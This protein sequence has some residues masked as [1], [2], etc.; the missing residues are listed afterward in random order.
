[1][2]DY[3][4]IYAGW[5]GRMNR[6]DCLELC[7][8]AHRCCRAGQDLI[9]LPGEG[10][11]L[12][13]QGL[14]AVGDVLHCEGRAQCFG[15]LRPICCRTFPV[16]PDAEGRLYANREC[17]E[18]PWASWHWLKQTE[19]AW[20]ELLQDRAVR[21][22]VWRMR[23]QFYA[24][25]PETPVEQIE[26][27]FDE[28][29]ARAFGRYFLPAPFQVPQEMFAGKRILDAGC[30]NG[31]RVAS[32]LA[33]GV[34]AWGVDINPY[35][36]AHSLAPERCRWGDM[37]ALPFGDGEFDMALTI[38][39][40]EHLLDF[41]RAVAELARVARKVIIRVTPTEEPE[42]LYE[43]S[44]HVTFLSTGEWARAIGKH[45]PVETLAVGWFGLSAE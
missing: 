33:A 35:L 29:Y 36:V 13:S 5:S 28:G 45:G 21:E 26:R 6:H 11:W 23:T 34:D 2:I 22:W 10:E 39:V 44:T 12:R 3:A 37:R 18:H 30:G 20:R 41:E 42:N 19:E 9:L 7:R 15:A 8:G 27:P 24:A 40:L 16:H 32:L 17:S 43:D 25:W 38:D 1:M 31:A 14:A 4:G